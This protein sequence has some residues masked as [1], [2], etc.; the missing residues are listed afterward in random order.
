MPLE[1]RQEN[2]Q[3][4]LR[5]I[6]RREA[7]TAANIRRATYA[8]VVQRSNNRPTLTSNLA[9]VSQNPLPT[10][11]LTPNPAINATDCIN[12]SNS[13]PTA[14]ATHKDKEDSFYNSEEGWILVT[15]KKSKPL[16]SSTK[17]ASTTTFKRDQAW[18]LQQRRCFK[19]FL[20][21][22]QKQQCRR[23]I[24][25]LQ[26]NKSGHISKQ[27]TG[28]IN[29]R[30][31]NEKQVKQTTFASEKGKL[32]EPN[33]EQ[34]FKKHPPIPNGMRK[35]SASFLQNHHAWLLNQGRCLKCFLKG[36]TKQQCIRQI[37][38]LTCNKEGH[39]SKQ[40]KS[41]S[42]NAKPTKPHRCPINA[43]TQPSQEHKQPPQTQ[44]HKQQFRQME[45][46]PNWETMDLMDPD[47]LEAGRRESMRVYLP[48]K[49]QLR[50]VNSYLDRSALVLSGPHQISRYLAHRLAVKL[51][52]Y[53][54][55]QP[56]D[57]II[58]RV[59][60]SYG[61]FLVQFPN[62]HLRDHAV[63]VCVF[64][65]GPDVQLQLVEWSPD[66]GR[67]YD[68]VTHMARLR[69][70]GLP[71]HNW[72]IHDLDIIV[73][74]FGHLLRVETFF[75]NGN[76]QEI[77]ILVG[78]FHPINIPQTIDLSEEPNTTIV[79]VVLEGWMYDG[80]AN[81]PRDVTNI[82]DNEDPFGGPR[83]GRRA[84]H[85]TAQRQVRH[86]RIITSS[87]NP[88]GSSNNSQT[89]GRQVQQESP[90]AM[91]MPLE[92]AV[93]EPNGDNKPMT[94]IEIGQQKEFQNFLIESN[95]MLFCLLFKQ[96]ALQETSK[97]NEGIKSSLQGL[98]CMQLFRDMCGNLSLFKE[99]D[100]VTGLKI[101]PSEGFTIIPPQT[102]HKENQ[103]GPILM[104][105]EP[106][107]PA[108][109]EID[110]YMGPPPGFEGPPAFAQQNRR[111]PRLMEKHGGKYVSILQ[112]AQIIKDG[113]NNE[114]P[115][116]PSKKKTRM[117]A[118]VQL[119]YSQSKDPLTTHQAEAVVATAG[120]ELGETLMDNIS[121]M[122]T[123]GTGVA[124]M[125]GV[126]A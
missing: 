38:C 87:S 115:F 33:K 100:Q 21:G 126:V 60:Q 59:N 42:I 116:L 121:K 82:D 105:I 58:T 23:E 54:N 4:I 112:R 63:A 44:V 37:K 102:A 96:L 53:F 27:C 40:C 34:D 56:K 64:T 14:P 24:K 84:Q 29:V 125:E 90:A 124:Q 30:T 83:Q 81:I 57:F 1:A 122:A 68:P 49:G 16:H 43:Q 55:M 18:L 51:A 71:L 118:Q 77:R 85:N 75:T 12:G 13:N 62:A 107:Q 119:T 72:N 32:Q 9:P 25:C 26:C 28:I 76:H 73:S 79:T 110:E 74:G 108:A 46:N 2:K 66:M 19:C 67:V 101:L 7:E 3:A 36:H 89:G 95:S 20:K 8:E 104:E 10:T 106:T 50:P 93:V 48:P 94:E 123:L 69:L 111:S 17:Q 70:Y 35:D 22:H 113:N 65:L 88:G 41:N 103:T 92:T 86:R 5:A 97:N 61:D 91:E 78:C 120:I 109:V 52:N 11:D 39:I 117:E 99:T 45:N 15:R 47:N 6:Q 80:T 114:G 98:T 31:P